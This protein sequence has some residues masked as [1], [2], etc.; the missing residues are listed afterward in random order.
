MSYVVGDCICGEIAGV[1]TCGVVE[2]CVG[3]LVYVLEG[4]A[5]LTPS[6]TIFGRCPPPP[7][8]HG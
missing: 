8:E 1:R 3:G 6:D 2:Y 4:G 7:R 5:I